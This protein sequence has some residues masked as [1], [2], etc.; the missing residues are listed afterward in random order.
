MRFRS[1]GARW[2]ALLLAL[3]AVSVIAAVTASAKQGKAQASYVI[4]VSNTLVGAGRSEE[5]FDDA[6]AEHAR[7]ARRVLRSQS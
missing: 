1:R 7:R 6:Y 5:L 4:G 2:A 3:V